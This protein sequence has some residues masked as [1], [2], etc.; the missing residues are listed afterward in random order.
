MLIR[1]IEWVGDRVHLHFFD[2]DGSHETM[3]LFPAEALDI[4]DWLVRETP[5]LLRL[6][7]EHLH[8]IRKEAGA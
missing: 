8:E 2:V 5:E 4:R 3:V 7:A 1:D 6:N